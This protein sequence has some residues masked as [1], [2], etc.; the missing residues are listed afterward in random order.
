MLASKPSIQNEQQ[1]R[2]EYGDDD[3]DDDDENDD[4]ES[5]DVEMTG[6]P[7]PLT[8][9]ENHQQRP[10]AYASPY[11]ISTSPALD[12]LHPQHDFYKSSLSGLPSPAIW[13]QMADNPRYLHQSPSSAS[14][15]PTLVPASSKEADEEATAALLMLNK[16]RRNTTISSS[17]SSGRGMSVK[18]LL[19]P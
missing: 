12:A 2:V 19:S 7:E 10:Q 6:P 18:D 8:L 3:D 13:P 14:T 17:S 4:G 9:H 1:L 16:D 11:S 15:S 5:T